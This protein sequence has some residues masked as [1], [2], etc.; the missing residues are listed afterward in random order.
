MTGDNA[1]CVDWNLQEGVHPM[2]MTKTS[3][4]V[5]Y[6]KGPGHVELRK[7]REAHEATQHLQ[8]ALCRVRVA[9]EPHAGRMIS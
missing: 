7:T 5:G 9:C 3:K 8:C 1:V 4:V 6:E 2:V